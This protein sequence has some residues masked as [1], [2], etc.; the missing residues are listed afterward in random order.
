M[1]KVLTSI[2]AVSYLRILISAMIVG[3]VVGIVT[4]GFRVFE[5]TNEQRLRASSIGTMQPIPTTTKRPP[6]PIPAEPPKITSVFPWVGKVGDAVLIAGVHF[7][8]N[9]SE[10]QISIGGVPIEDN[11]I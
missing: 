1:K 8:D 5:R 2:A 3:A 10:K 7:G 11:Q 6:G 9:P 4:V